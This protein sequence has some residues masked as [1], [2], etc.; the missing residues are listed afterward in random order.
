VLR[1]AL[2][3]HVI[4]A[5]VAA[6]VSSFNASAVLRVAPVALFQFAFGTTPALSA[7]P[8]AVVFPTKSTLIALPLPVTAVTV[9]D[10]VVEWASEPLVPVI[11][12]LD[13]PAGV[14]ATVVT[15]NVALSDAVIDAGVNDA[16][17]VGGNPLTLRVT[18]LEKPFNAPV[19]TV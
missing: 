1:T 15:F 8:I 16:V 6:P 2:D 13:V 5:A 19:V 11:V 10:T 14:F 3:A 9:N 12:R 17:A 7:A 4:V 18:A